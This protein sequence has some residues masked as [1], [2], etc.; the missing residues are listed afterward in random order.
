MH[1]G[2]LN[3]LPSGE[4]HWDVVPMSLYADLLAS[5]GDGFTSTVYDVADGELP[6]APSECDGYLI[7]GSPRSAFDED[8]WIEELARFLRASRSAGVRLV[9]LCFGHQMLASAFGGDVERAAQ[10]WG[11]GPRDFELRGDPPWIDDTRACSLFFAHRDQIKK[12][13]PGAECLGGDAFCPIGVF[14]IGDG[15]LGIQG[16]P[17]F[18]RSIM[19]QIYASLES[20]DA[21]VLDRARRSTVDFQPD[22]DRVARWVAAFLTQKKASGAHAAVAR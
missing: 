8:V 6:S 4:I 18:T 10:G 12:L 15:V 2:I 14:R 7:T 3:A 5:G 1:I 9:G 21:D 11:L 19:E 20:V 16:H 17:E 13:P 22:S